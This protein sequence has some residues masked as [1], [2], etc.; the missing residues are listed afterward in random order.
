VRRVLTSPLLQGLIVQYRLLR[1]PRRVRVHG[2]TIAVDPAWPPTIL[3]KLYDGSYECSE[4]QV[5]LATLRPS[6]QYL[7]LGAGIGVLTT[8][9]C[10]ILGDV[11]VTAVEADPALAGVAA[12]TAAR[13]GHRPA[14][15]NAVL[16]N[17]G[18]SERRFYVCH[19]FWSS[20]LLPSSDANE[21]VVPARPFL[22][23]L[24]RTRATY[25]VVDIEG[26]EAELLA[27]ELPASVRAVCVE[28][29]PDRI[30]D[31]AVQRLITHLIDQ[32]FVL[33]TRLLCWQVLFFARDA[34]TRL[35]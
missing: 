15:V 23:E 30:G 28:V 2:V 26:G 24:E 4:A 12:K 31:H 1:R 7:E 19:D 21:I 3:D 18:A 22:A 35:P 14:I 6:D 20:S 33:D 10:R 17:D 34:Y 8:I 5:L 29:H 16:T 32:G 11:D 27:P 25:L 9:A 13:N